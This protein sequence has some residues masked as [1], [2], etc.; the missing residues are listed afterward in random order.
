MGLVGDFNFFEQGVEGFVGFVADVSAVE[1]AMFGGGAGHC[2]EFGGV[3]VAADI[4]F[5]AARKTDGAFVHGL[6]GEL[7]HFFDFGLRGDAFE[8]LAHDLFANGGVSGENSDVESGGIFAARSDPV[9]DRP[10]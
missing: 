5:E 4:V 2:D 6:P 9:G 8:V 7:S 10:R 1:A 3:A